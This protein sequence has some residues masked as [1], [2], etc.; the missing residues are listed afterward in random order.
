MK[1]VSSLLV[2]FSLVG[3]GG[4]ANVNS[5]PEIPTY[6]KTSTILLNEEKTIDAMS[7]G[8]DIGGPIVLDS[9]HR[10]PEVTSSTQHDI[11]YES[12][13]KL[14]YNN[15]GTLNKI[16]VITNDRSLTWEN[17]AMF[18]N[19]VDDTFGMG[20][21]VASEQP[22]S[23]SGNIALFVN[24]AVTNSL[25]YNYQAFGGWLGAE[26]LGNDLWNG[27]IGAMSIGTPTASVSVPSTGVSAFRGYTTGVHVSASPEDAQTQ[28]AF[29]ASEF[30]LNADFAARNLSFV[31]TNTNVHIYGWLT[32]NSDLDLS[33][34]LTYSP[35]TNSFTGG[36]TSAGGMAGSASGRFYGPNAEEVGGLFSV[37]D[38]SVSTYTGSFGGKQ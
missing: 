25:A 31:T 23:T 29:T 28:T 14:S 5:V 10:R 33:G 35:A 2:L 22:S 36:V 21:V 4:A 19:A 12:Q 11:D 17:S 7:V 38:G 6:I 1:K 26:D 18:V 27:Y 24:P 32:T 20:I 3:C 8:V 37:S 30:L 15:D 9:T 13:A 16:S 34:T